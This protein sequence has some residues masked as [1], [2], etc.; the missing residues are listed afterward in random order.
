[1]NIN[2]NNYPHSPHGQFQLK[3]I[4]QCSGIRACAVK[5]DQRERARQSEQLSDDRWH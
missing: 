4:C 3:A 5:N 1:M 2:I